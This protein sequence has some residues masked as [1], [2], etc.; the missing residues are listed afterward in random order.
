MPLF[1]PAV[2]RRRSTPS[3][4]IVPVKPKPSISTPI[5][6]TRLALSTIDLVGG[7]RDVVGA[8]GAHL[9]DHRVH[10][11]LVLG[12]Q[13]PDLVV[14]DA[15]LHRAAARAVDAQHHGLRAA[16]SNALLSA[17]TRFSA[18]ASPSAAI[19]PRTSISAVCGPLGATGVAARARTAPTAISR[20]RSQPR[21]AEEDA[22]APLA[23]ALAHQLAGEVRHAALEARRSARRR[24]RCR[25]RRRVAAWWPRSRRPAEADMVPGGSW[26][27]FSGARQPQA[28]RRRR[29][30]AGCR[31]KDTNTPAVTLRRR[32]SAIRRPLP[33][34]PPTQRPSAGS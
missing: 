32:R 17:A 29:R 11:L 9:L 19:S 25:G 20:A 16:S 10:L 1:S 6:P 13:A 27:T 23:A 14:D 2:S 33:Q 8:R 4:S 12:L 7:D 31:G 15:G 3:F 22:P 30:P 18:L 24:G 21:Q 34:G 28:R 26:W 5:E